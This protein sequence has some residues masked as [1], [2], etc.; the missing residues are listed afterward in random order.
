VAQ[1]ILPESYLV[2]VDNPQALNEALSRVLSNVERA[3]VD[4]Q[5]LFDWARSTFTIDHMAAQTASIYQERY[6]QVGQ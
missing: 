5:S 2:P 3:L 6:Q 4:Q 1:E